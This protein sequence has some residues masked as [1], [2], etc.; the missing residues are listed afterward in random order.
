MVLG[1][2]IGAVAVV[3]ARSMKACE[4]AEGF[5]EG[6]TIARS[7]DLFTNTIECRR[8]SES[9]AVKTTRLDV[10]DLLQPH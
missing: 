4:H 8:T 2:A 9:G 6:Y 10:W 3:G 1:L 5:L 7:Y